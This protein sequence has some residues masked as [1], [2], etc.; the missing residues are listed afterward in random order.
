MVRPPCDEAII[1]S[2]SAVTPCRK[3]AEPW[4]L[5]ATILGS[6]MAF[7][8]GTVVNVALPALQSE[9]HATVVDV[10]WVIE[11]YA[12]ILAALLLAGGSL[13]DRFGRRLVYSI[14]IVVFAIASACC[15]LISSVEQLIV[16]RAVQGLG[17]A[18]LVPGSL[19]IISVSF[20]V[21]ARGKA[22]GTWSGF[23]SITAAVGPVMGG[24]LIQNVS[25]RAAFYLNIPISVI[26]LLL[27]FRFVPESRDRKEDSGVDWRGTVLAV[28]G[29]A[30]LIYGLIESSNLG[31]SHA[32]V[33]F[34]LIAGTFLL[35]AFLVVESRA[36]NAMLPLTLFR[37][38]DFSGANILTFL[39]Y[40]A[41]SAVLFFYPLNLIQ[42]QGY[43]PTAAGAAL[44]PFILIMF[45]LSRWSG[46][47]VQRYGAKL[48]L[49][50][51]PVIAAAGLV[52]FAVPT[53]SGN[54]WTSFFPAV[55]VLG[56]GMAI[57]VAPLTT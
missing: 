53:T 43:S 4:I 9:L 45:A 25:W 34:T 15:G 32:R 22:I 54:Y 24:W 19:A 48:P 18:L 41:L 3:T 37:S 47:L 20:S 30:S 49:S 21:E 31:F 23:T 6:S 17:A 13:G 26:V 55:I 29:L 11:S 57:S 36:R 39:L 40:S 28:S 12:L 16:A 33:R 44:L 52:L 35:A 5:A 42:V 14:G 1:R 50:V 51:G 10:Q 56:V 7:I 2:R 8:D 46:G 27:V 38:R